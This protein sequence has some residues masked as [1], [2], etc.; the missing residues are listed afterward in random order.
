LHHNN[1]FWI[2][3]TIK[4]VVVNVLLWIDSCYN[5]IQWMITVNFTL[6]CNT[7]IQG[8]SLWLRTGTDAILQTR[9]SL[10][11]CMRPTYID[12]NWICVTAEN[13]VR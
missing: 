7:D 4:I 12:S 13:K 11:E 6:H 5:L 9:T 8:F 3:L 10:D 2:W 1:D